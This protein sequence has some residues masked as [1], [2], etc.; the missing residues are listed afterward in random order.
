VTVIS[1]ELTRA[2]GFLSIVLLLQ[3]E[4]PQSPV[5]STTMNILIIIL[6]TGRFNREGREEIAMK[7]KAGACS[8]LITDH[9]S[10][11][12]LLTTSFLLLSA[13]CFPVTIGRDKSCLPLAA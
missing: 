2:C 3:A 11:I 12:L 8:L 1:F 9:S 4:I 6:F 7:R 5:N 13:F 10:L